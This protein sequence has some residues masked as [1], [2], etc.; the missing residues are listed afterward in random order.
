M[1]EKNTLTLPYGTVKQTG[2]ADLL[3][4]VDRNCKNCKPF[5]LITCVSGCKTW[6]LKNEFRKLHEKTRK[7]DFMNNL[8]NT[9]KNNRRLQLLQI[10]TRKHCSIAQI[11]K[12]L[13]KRGF[14][15]SQQTIG[16][17][18]MKPLM[19]VG[20][21]DEHQNSYYATLFGRKISDLT[22][23]FHD[24]GELLSPHSECYE[25]TVLDAL[26]K[27][28]NTREG[29]E[30]IIPEKSIARV[31]S[32]L[33]KA[34]LAGTSTDKDYIFFFATKRDPNRPDLSPTEKRVY[35]RLPK[36]GISAK[37]LAREAGISIRRTYK[38]LRKLKGKKLVFTRKKPI[39]Y[40]ITAK[41][42]KTAKMLK[43]MHDL[44]T[45][46]LAA[47]ARLF[48]DGQTRDEGASA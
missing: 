40:T 18:Y 24:L 23:D 43:D 17:E 31:L 12:E 36:E 38:Y 32:R 9:L 1:E 42:A 14:N 6:K 28:P 41:G 15:H 30:Q 39:S 29:L 10:I 21:A 35:E 48:G 45:E 44:A 26:S 2:L 33:Q 46:A 16:R 3:Q 13:W 5:A 7:P 47:T 25:E 22:M 19:A 20:I 4:A 11:Q 34:E 27:G 8:L 37:K